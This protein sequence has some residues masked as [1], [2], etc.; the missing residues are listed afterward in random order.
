M[1]DE[2]AEGNIWAPDTMDPDLDSWV[3]TDSS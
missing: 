3:P 1:N 2:I